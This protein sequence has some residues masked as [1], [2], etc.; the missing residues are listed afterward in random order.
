MVTERGRFSKAK[1]AREKPSAVLHS[2]TASRPD[3]PR[4]LGQ[5]F[6]ADAGWR[7]RI[8][9]L[10]CARPGD[11]WL[12]IGA[13]HGEMTRELARRA[14]R[15]AAIELD[16]P[17]LAALEA[18]RAEAPNV[19]VVAGDVL[20]LDLERAAGAARFRVYGNLPYYITS[21]IL[22]RLFE[23]ADRIESIHIVIQLEVAA[24]LVA[25]PGRRDYGYL[26]VLAQYFARPE[27]LLRIPPGA[28]RPP[29]KVT[30]ALVGLRLPGE[31]ARLAVRDEA[32]F[33]RF[34]QR[35]FAQKRKTLANNLRAWL[36]ADEA[37]AALEAAGI[38]PRAR[39]EELS[40]EE[41]A[42]L[43]AGTRQ[44]RT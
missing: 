15:V 3:V 33:M 36:K 22:H 9:N 13:G 41:F 5:H 4:R 28:F 2:R 34:V 29:P 10:L 11:V 37:A 1:R 18:L 17:L 39:A 26:S 38:K 44:P 21:P 16:P 25:R 40:L 20:K 23:I 31:R 12:E 8:L 30:S 27:I 24:R 42:R 7:A 35:C 19:E 14:E 43:F 32:S 6:L